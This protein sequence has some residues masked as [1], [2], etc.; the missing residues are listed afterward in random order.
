MRETTITIL[1]DNNAGSSS[2]KHE[3]G[4]SMFLTTHDGALFFDTGQSG[5]FMDNARAMNIPVESASCA[6]MSHGHYDHT[7]GL[8]TLFDTVPDITV[9]AHPGIFT[10]RY[11]PGAEGNPP[12]S[13]GIPYSEDHIRQRS[14]SLLATAEIT[15]VLPGSYMTGEIPRLNDFEDTGGA[16]FLDREL[17]IPDLLADDQSLVIETDNGLILLLG[18]CHAGLINT[19]SYVSNVF[20]T[21]RFSLIAGGMHLLNADDNRLKKTISSLRSFTV[22]RIAP[23]HCT[24]DKAIAALNSAFPGDVIPLTSG[25]TWT[26]A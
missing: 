16:F 7:G 21:R 1:I 2:L 25:W 24:G 22:G 13:I 10:T 4:L 20:G 14:G 18:C 12:R 11:T 5:G 26:I 17:T 23:G 8:D 3:H 6:V 9:H 19:M 15:P